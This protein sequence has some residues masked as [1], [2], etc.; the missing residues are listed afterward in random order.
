MGLG[1]EPFCF[2]WWCLQGEQLYLHVP[3]T[4][5]EYHDLESE[6]N[7]DK[8][9][10]STWICMHVERVPSDSTGRL[11]SVHGEFS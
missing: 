10:T 7:K 9:L 3:D 2:L 4:I 8:L 5:V 11:L 6:I 1:R